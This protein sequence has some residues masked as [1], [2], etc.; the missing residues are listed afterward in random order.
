MTTTIRLPATSSR[1]GADADC[2]TWMKILL[3]VSADAKNG[4]GFQGEFVERG[5]LINSDDIP[6]HCALLECAGNDG[7]AKYPEQLIILW[8]RNGDQITEID[9]AS[10][11][12]WAFKLRDVA[13][14]L[15]KLCSAPCNEAENQIVVAHEILDR[16]HAHK[17][18]LDRLAEISAMYTPKE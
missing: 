18:S 5:K 1:R 15:V 2:K 8:E 11:K 7:S 4:F 9:R 12:E 6:E 14:E 3:G 13:G 16:L 10:G 17:I